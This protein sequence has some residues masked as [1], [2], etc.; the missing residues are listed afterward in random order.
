MANT[1]APSPRRRSVPTRLL[2]VVSPPWPRAL[3]QVASFRYPALRQSRRHAPCRPRC[4]PERE[5]VQQARVLGRT[6]DA[7]R[8]G[9]FRFRSGRTPPDAAHLTSFPARVVCQPQCSGCNDP[10]AERVNEARRGSRPGALIRART[11][12]AALITRRLRGGQ[13]RRSQHCGTVGLKLANIPAG[14]CSN[15]QMWNIHTPNP[16][17]RVNGM[18]KNSGGSALCHFSYGTV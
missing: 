16:S 15:S 4:R 9:A 12:T 8:V 13:C 7:T 2:R 3:R 18:P 6:A 11:R 10:R 5:S 1:A 17:L 14:L